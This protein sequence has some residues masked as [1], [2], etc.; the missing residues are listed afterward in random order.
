MWQELKNKQNSS[1][2][3]DFTSN[4]VYMSE[5]ESEEVK[6]YFYPP[7]KLYYFTT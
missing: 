5:K 4:S 3:C 7:P 2:I 1:C 6:A